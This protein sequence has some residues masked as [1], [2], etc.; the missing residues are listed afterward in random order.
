MSTPIPGIS[1]GKLCRLRDRRAGAHIRLRDRRAG[2]HI[3][4]RRRLGRWLRRTNGV[5]R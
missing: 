1:M 4:R 3:R 5:H 2:A